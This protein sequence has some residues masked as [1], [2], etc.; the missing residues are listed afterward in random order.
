MS[1][2][3]QNSELSRRGCLQSGAHTALAASTL[4]S[5]LWAEEQ[6]SGKSE[7]ESNVERLFDS[8]TV[9]QKKRVCFDWNH[10]DPQRGLLRTF[11]ANN[12][13]ITRPEVKSEFYTPEQRAL[14]RDIFEGIIQPD[15]HA[16]FDKQLEDDSGGFGHDQSIRCSWAL[17]RS[18]LLCHGWTSVGSRCVGFIIIIINVVIITLCGFLAFALLWSALQCF[19]GSFFYFRLPA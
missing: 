15:W 16:R 14:I 4:S 2:I 11:I 10:Q 6:N 19:E 3:F 18:D 9:G 13:N 8:L 7:P 12:W 1:G 5:T 17:R